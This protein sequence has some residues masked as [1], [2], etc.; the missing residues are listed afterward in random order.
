LFQQ[1][2]VAQAGI[3][4]YNGLRPS[5]PIHNYYYTEERNA[6]TNEVIAVRYRFIYLPPPQE[7]EDHKHTTISS[8]DAPKRGCL[9]CWY[10]AVEKKDKSAKNLPTK[11]QLSLEASNVTVSVKGLFVAVSLDRTR[12]TSE[13]IFSFKGLLNRV[14]GFLAR[15][16]IKKAHRRQ[17]EAFKRFAEAHR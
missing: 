3:L 6:S 8:V 15:G 2:N 7:R 14:F 16:A 12:L 11:S 10:D 5:W 1:P 9:Q 4:A 13:E 17:M